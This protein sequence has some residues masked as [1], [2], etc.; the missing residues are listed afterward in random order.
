MSLPCPPWDNNNESGALESIVSGLA[1]FQKFAARNA[2]SHILT[3]GDIKTWHQNIFQKAVPVPYYAGHFRSDDAKHPCLAVNVTVGAGGPSGAPYSDV[4]G[5][6][7]A[8]SDD[9][10][11]LTSQ[12]DEYISKKPTPSDRARAAIQLAALYVGRFIRIHPFINGNGRMSRAIANY[13]FERYGYPA[14]HYE[15]F[16]RPGPAYSSAAAAS[17]QGDFVPL[18]RYLLSSLAR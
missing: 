17:M 1:A 16:P 8:L 14:P 11:T 2:K 12:T 7:R 6:M 15:L 3:H 5:L 10:Q 9:M 13:F 4:P 18:F